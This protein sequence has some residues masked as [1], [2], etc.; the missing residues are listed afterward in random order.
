[1]G[2]TYG[3][4]GITVAVRIGFDDN[5][6]LGPGET[7]GRLALPVFRELMLAIYDGK[8]VGNAPAFPAWM[9]A[10]ITAALLPPPP[11]VILTAVDGERRMPAFGIVPAGRESKTTPARR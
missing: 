11:P 4:T 5:R 3:P 8:I 9:E 2:S 1:V 7:G 10:R 6:S